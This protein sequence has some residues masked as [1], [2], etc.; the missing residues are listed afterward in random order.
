M[1]RDMV[2]TAGEPEARFE[3]EPVG[4]VESPLADR[5]AAPKQGVRRDLHGVFSTR[6]PDRPN[7]I[8]L[9]EVT[10]VEIGTNAITVNMLE[11]VD[12]TPVLDIK[13]VLPGVR[14]R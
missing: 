11:A 8:G 5:D 9:H 13:P 4:W 6:S 2:E 14:K 10:I 1:A 3:V 12:G 7:P